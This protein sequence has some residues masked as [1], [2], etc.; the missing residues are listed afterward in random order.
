V[1]LG[2]V[3]Y[4]GTLEIEIGG[5]LPGSGY[6]QLNHSIG[7][8]M[9]LLGGTLEVSLW[10]GFT[11][12]LGDEFEFLTANGGVSGTFAAVNYPT[13]PAGLDWQ[14]GYEPNAVHLNVVAAPRYTADF[15][16]DGDVDGTD[17]AS[18]K[19]GFATGSQHGDGDADADVDVDGA[20]LI[21]WQQQAGSGT[22]G[23]VTAL[24]VPE[25]GAWKLAMIAFLLAAEKVSP[26]SLTG[27]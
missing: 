17:L 26:R 25:P 21:A 16:E 18:W 23:T 14:L 4:A 10:G 22:A 8:G 12:A 24:T 27:G 19:G 2:S 20:D 5:T 7:G 9:A 3:I 1:K 11:P 13:L 6:D 15:D